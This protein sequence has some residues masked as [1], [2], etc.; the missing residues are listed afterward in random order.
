[1]GWT[2]FLPSQ[3]QQ[4]GLQQKL[5]VIYLNAHGNFQFLHTLQEWRSETEVA[6]M[7]TVGEPKLPQPSTIQLL[8]PRRLQSHHYPTGYFSSSEGARKA[9]GHLPL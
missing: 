3:L 1:M 4:S 6:K 8:N 5:S 7:V 9:E 2:P